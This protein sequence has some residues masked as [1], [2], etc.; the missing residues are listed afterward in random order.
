M[1]HPFYHM[2]RGALFAGALDSLNWNEA[3]AMADRQMDY[4][5]AAFAAEGPAF[6]VLS[7][8]LMTDNYKPP[9]HSKGEVKA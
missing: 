7:S 6:L 2:V 3:E 1:R 4:L 8:F 5:A 9:E